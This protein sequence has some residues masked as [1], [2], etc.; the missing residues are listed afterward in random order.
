MLDSL[1]CS[2]EQYFLGSIRGPGSCAK[3]PL[4][5]AP[6]HA[7]LPIEVTA[8]SGLP[9]EVTSLPQRGGRCHYDRPYYFLHLGSFEG[10][11]GV[12]YVMTSNEDRKTP[13]RSVMWTVES[14]QYECR[15]Y[16]NFRS[17]GHVER[18]GAERWLL[19]GGWHL[20]H[21][22]RSPVS[23]GTPNG[24]YSGPTYSK[25]VPPKTRA[26]LYGSECWEGTYFVFVE[27]LSGS[28]ST[29]AASAAAAPAPIDAEGDHD[30]P[31]TAS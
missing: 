12:L 16:L 13:S 10:M 22:I 23:S 28:A 31:L 17:E 14:H 2:L 7:P 18:G 6:V 24:P 30:E 25:V 9:I 21:Q 4:C 1:S 26:L 5:R 11:R 8:T 27:V 15:V 20:D 3:C 19:A 29:A